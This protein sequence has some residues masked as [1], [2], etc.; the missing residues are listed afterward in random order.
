MLSQCPMDFGLFSW[1]FVSRYLLISYLMSLL[2][3]S[4]FNNMLFSFQIFAFSSV[5]FLWLISSFIALC[6]EKMLDMISIIL[7]LLRPVLCPNMWS[8]LE[9]VPCALE[10]HVYSAALGE[11]LWRYQLN[12]FDLECC[13]RPVSLLIFCL[14][15][16]SIEVNGV[17][18]SLTMTVFLWISSFLFI[19]ICFTYIGAPMLGA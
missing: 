5:L 4:L 18:K 11:M 3:H 16:L 8:I 13:L 19:K 15:D 10:K 6:S 7:N 2:T 17:L 9:N 1:S 12:P 14:K